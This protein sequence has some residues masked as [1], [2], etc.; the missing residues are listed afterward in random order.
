[1]DVKLINLL[2]SKTALNALN[3]ISFKAIYSC[4][5]NKIIKAVNNELQN[6]D[7]VLKEKRASYF[8]KGAE[9]DQE[10]IDKFENEMNEATQDVITLDVSNVKLSWFAKSNGAINENTDWH[11]FEPAHFQALSWLIVDDLE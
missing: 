6:F 11:E 8:S 2:Q 1:M 5:I 3:N 9:P 10:D 4:R 7:E